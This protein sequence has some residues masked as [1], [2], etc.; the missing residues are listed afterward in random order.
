MACK[1]AREDQQ[2]ELRQALDDIEK[3]VKSRKTQFEAGAHGLQAYRVQAIQ[4]YFRMVVHNGHKGIEA[5]EMAA[6]THGFARQW[7]H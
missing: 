4:S 6:E 2:R 5:L 7:G 3:V 1:T